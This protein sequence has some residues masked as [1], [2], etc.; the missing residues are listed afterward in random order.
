MSEPAKKRP[1]LGTEFGEARASRVET[2]EFARADPSRPS[3]VVSFRYNDR[4]G[5]VALGIVFPQPYAS[6]ENDL[7]LRESADPFRENHF[8]QPPP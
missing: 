3:Q 8:A 5:L 6:V 1:G 7:R 4:A 2:T